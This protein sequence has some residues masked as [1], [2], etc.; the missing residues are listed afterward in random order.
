MCIALCA[1][2]AGQDST[3]EFDDIFHSDNAKQMMAK[4]LVGKLKGYESGAG[5]SGGAAYKKQKQSN[6]MLYL[7]PVILFAAVIYYQMFMAN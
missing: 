2:C 7:L 5:S 1:T 6:G 3:E 4:Y